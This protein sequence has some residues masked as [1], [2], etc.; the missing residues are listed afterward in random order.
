MATLVFI[1]QATRSNAGTGQHQATKPSGV[2]S[3]SP[4]SLAS[5]RLGSD[6]EK[7]EILGKGAFGTVMKVS[8]LF[9]IRT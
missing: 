7:L 9:Y 2:L 1:K 5:S 3:S 6:F 4:N 8:N